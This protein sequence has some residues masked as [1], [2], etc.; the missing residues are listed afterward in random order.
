MQAGNEI[1]QIKYDSPFFKCHEH[2]SNPSRKQLYSTSYTK[3]DLS[4]LFSK[5]KEGQI[6]NLPPPFLVLGDRDLNPDLLIQSQLSCRLDDPPLAT[7]HI[8]T[9]KGVISKYKRLS[10]PSIGCR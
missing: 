9:Y 4:A 7:F 3:Y 2:S 10:P 1:R 5:K 8:L 6:E